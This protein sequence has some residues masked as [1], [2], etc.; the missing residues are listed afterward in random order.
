[1]S[2][3]ITSILVVLFAFPLL[4]LFS[5][6]GGTVVWMAWPI[7]VKAF[8]GIVNAG[9]IVPEISWGSA[10]CLS[11]ITSVLFKSRNG[12]TSKD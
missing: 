3:K 1:M 10:V 11:F 6:L 2:G 7:A 12:S 4:L 8:P 5:L 9:Y